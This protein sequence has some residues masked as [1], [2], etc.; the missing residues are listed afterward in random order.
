MSERYRMGVD[1]ETMSHVYPCG[2]FVLIVGNRY[3]L[4]QRA[5]HKVCEVCKKI[6]LVKK[7]PVVANEKRATVTTTGMKPS[8]SSEYHA[9]MI[10]E[11]IRR[12]R[13]R[14]MSN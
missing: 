5:H 3:K 9:M 14:V 4:H 1:V 2:K 8:M 13:N 10:D 11:H 12:S 7:D 6:P